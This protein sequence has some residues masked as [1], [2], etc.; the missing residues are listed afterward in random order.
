MSQIGIAGSGGPIG[1]VDGPT[2]AVSTDNAITRWDGTT[3]RVIQNSVVIVDDTGILNTPTNI[4][5]GNAAPGNAFD[6]TVE[7][8]VA[9]AIGSSIQNLSANAAASS[10]DELIVAAGGGDAYTEYVVNGATTWSAGID[11]S[12]SDKWKLT[13]GASPSAGTEAM[14]VTTAGLTTLNSL[15]VSGLTTQG[16]GQVIKRT[17]TAI[18]YVVLV[19]DYLIAVTSTALARTITLPAAPASGQSFVIKDESGACSTN[20]ITVTVAGGVITI[21]GATTLVLNGDYDGYTVYFNGTAY[22]TC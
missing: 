2:P 21:D 14:S 22:F 16:A 1:N 11:N 13:T 15:T 19:T 4:Y 18:S 17:A 6:I 7:K 20:N 12:D 5:I 8:T 10:V 3:G 9:G